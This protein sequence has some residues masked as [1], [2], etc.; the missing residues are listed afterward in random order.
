MLL[1]LVIVIVIVIVIAIVIRIVYSHMYS[2]CIY[3]CVGSGT[4]N[5]LFCVISCEFCIFRIINCGGL[6][7]YLFMWFLG[8]TAKT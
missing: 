5:F 4:D 2:V 7:G 8:V 1:P 6:R 3:F